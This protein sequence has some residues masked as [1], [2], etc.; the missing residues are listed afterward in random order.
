MNPKVCQNDGRIYSSISGK[1]TDRTT[2]STGIQACQLPFLII[3]G[4]NNLQETFT[5]GQ[6]DPVLDVTVTFAASRKVLVR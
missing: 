6:C 4:L 5:V 3:P 1:E 2:T